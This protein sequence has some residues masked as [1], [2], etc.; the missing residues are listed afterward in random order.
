[1]SARFISRKVVGALITLVFVVCFNFFLFRV[2]ETDP[3]ASLFRGKEL[4]QSQRAE[5]TKEFGLDGSQAEQFWSY[6]KQ[7]ATLNLGRSYSTNQPVASEIR[8]KALPTIAL[9]GIADGILR[10]PKRARLLARW[11][12]CL[13]GDDRRSSDGKGQHD[14]MKTFDH[15]VG[16]TRLRI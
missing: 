15:H 7:T 5:L 12:W 2:V 9:V 6:L 13:C 16:G 3:V 10:D 8:S 11:C 14:P 1:M 4:S